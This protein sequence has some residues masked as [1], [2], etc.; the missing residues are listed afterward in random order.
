[1]KFKNVLIERKSLLIDQGDICEK[2]TD[3][4]KENSGLIS[5]NIETKNEK[6]IF[7]KIEDTLNDLDGAYKS[8]SYID[9]RN[10]LGIGENSRND[11]LKHSDLI[12]RTIKELFRFTDWIDDDDKSG[13]LIIFDPINI[14][15]RQG[16]IYRPF[17]KLS[18]G[19]RSGI[20][21]RLILS[22]TNK[23]IV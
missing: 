11:F 22:N 23:D 6:S 19:Q 18:F 1:M 20:I 16:N 7:S 8:Y 3:C 9:Q 4:F 5:I 17:E 14:S 15:M 2:L 10:S 12:G 13:A 21:L